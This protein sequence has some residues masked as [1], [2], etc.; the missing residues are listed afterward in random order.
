VVR[1][2]FAGFKVSGT[3]PADHVV[4]VFANPAGEPHQRT[5]RQACNQQKIAATKVNEQ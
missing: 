1:D 5:I 2:H 4:D 3:H